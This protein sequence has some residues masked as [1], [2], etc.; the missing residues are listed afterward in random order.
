VIKFKF[1]GL[2]VL[3]NKFQRASEKGVDGLINILDVEADN[4]QKRALRDVPVDTGRLKNSFFKNGIQN[5]A[6][7]QYFIGFK[8]YYAAYKEFGTGMGLRIAGDYSEFSG[9]AKDFKTTDFPENYTRQK[10]YLL[11]AFIL[12]RRAIDK[13]NITAVKNLIK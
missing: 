2:K 1:E 3:S 5:G 13:K 7:V 8:E 4:I 9:Y 11:N 6:K 10:K 12:S